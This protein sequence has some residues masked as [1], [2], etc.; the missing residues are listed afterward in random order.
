MTESL[1]LRMRGWAR[2]G[3]GRSIA[4]LLVLL[5]VLMT[6]SIPAPAAVDRVE[7]ILRFDSESWIHRDGSLTVRETIE[8]NAARYNIR[9]G[10]YRDFPTTYN[11]RMGTRYTVGFD[12][13]EITRDGRREPYHTEMLS[14]G[15]RVYIGSKD[16]DLPPGHYVYTITYRTDRQLYFGKDF[17]E[18][19]WNVTG[20]DWKFPI[21]L[22]RAIIHLP[23]GARVRDYSAYTGPMGAKGQDFTYTPL[24]DGA[25]RFQTTR[26]LG[27]GEGLTVAVSWPL[28][29]IDRPTAAQKFSYFLRDNSV[30]AAG[31]IGLTVLLLYYLYFWVKV[32]RDPA[33]G[34][35]VPLYEPPAAI[36]PAGAR[37]VNEFGFDNKAF[38]AAV[39]NMAVKGYLTIRQDDDK[40]FTLTATGK[41]APLSA[42][43]RAIARHLFPTGTGTIELKQKNHL[44]LGAAKKALQTRLR[45]EFE[46]TY[47]LYNT[48]YFIPGAIL[49]VLM[50]GVIA[51]AADVP[52]VAAFM[53]VW[54][55]GWSVGVF[56]LGTM[57]WRAWKA[58]IAGGGI[59]N[60]IGALF[61]S[62]FALPFFGAEIMGLW[63]YSQVASYAGVALLVLILAVNLLFY[64]LL[65]A[66]TRL[67]RQMM[68]KIE[69]FKLY[70]SVAEKDR[71]NMLN[72]PE[73]TPELFEKFLPY[74]LA[75][76]VEQQWAEQFAGVIDAAGT[77]PGGGGRGYTPIWYSGGALDRGLSGFGSSLGGAFSGSIASASTAPGSSGGSS[78]SSGGGSS[79][80][81]GGGGGGGGW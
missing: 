19:Y 46:R 60:G 39:V 10:I 23:D 2:K 81:G 68:D 47:F 22:A 51:L 36:S 44:Y 14:N 1:T 66:P 58:A 78:G 31:G 45:N 77:A 7:R 59:G 53:T 6:V 33:R 43:E 18:L 34:V 48:R 75:L 52:A 55:S 63:F 38:T 3:G 71:M 65:K 27:P 54:L 4:V 8:V 26:P 49:S 73:R 72:P 62:A 24:V 30:L 17:D 13:E 28:G 15:V 50:L 40:T 42:G 61:S 69:G 5:A 9:H 32:G 21:M 64:Q 20:N 37:Y 67:G 57:A 80:G 41:E 29:Y 12:I 11:D 74:A 70:L 79:G 16:M 25:V 56:F 35:I 76:D